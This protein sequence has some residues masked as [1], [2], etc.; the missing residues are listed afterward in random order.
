MCEVFKSV[1]SSELI[2]RDH[3]GGAGIRGSR[4]NLPFYCIITKT[5]S[6][7]YFV[8]HLWISISIPFCY[9]FLQFAFFDDPLLYFLEISAPSS[10]P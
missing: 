3:S 8:A 7:H 1:T 5:H 10:Y 4:D 2:T 6:F 9:T